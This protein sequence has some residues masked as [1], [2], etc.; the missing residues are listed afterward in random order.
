MESDLIEKSFSQKA[1]PSSVSPKTDF[2]HDP[3]Q[4]PSIWDPIEDY[5]DPPR[6]AFDTS[7]NAARNPNA[8]PFE[9]EA[10]DEPDFK[11]GR[12]QDRQ[13]KERE[14]WYD[15]LR[16][17]GGR[18]SNENTSSS[19][20]QSRQETKNMSLRVIPDYW[21]VRREYLKSKRIKNP[22][23]DYP[24]SALVK[25][26]VPYLNEW[27]WAPKKGRPRTF[28]RTYYARKRFGRFGAAYRRRYRGRG[29]YWAEMLTGAGAIG[30]DM[31]RKALCETGTFGGKQGLNRG[32]YFGSGAYVGPGGVGGLNN[33]S[34]VAP[35]SRLEQALPTFANDDDCVILSNEEY[36]GDVKSPTSV[37]DFQMQLSAG[38]NP[39]NNDLFPWLSRV[40]SMFQQYEFISLIFTYK[41]M[42]GALSTTQALGQVMMSTQYNVYEARPTTKQEMLNTVFA[43]SKVPSEDCMHAVECER[44][45]STAGGLLFIR[46]ESL[47][48]G[49]DARFYDLG[50]FNIATGGQSSAT[51]INLGQ[52]WVS[53]KVKLCKPQMYQLEVSPELSGSASYLAGSATAAAPLGASGS[54]S[55]NNIG[56]SIA[57]ISSVD[58]I[59]QFPTDI[60]SGVVQISIW[61]SADANTGGLVLPT[62]IPPAEW[63]LITPIG[64]ATPVVPFPSAGDTISTRLMTVRHYKLAPLSASTPSDSPNW[65]VQVNTD[66]VLPTTSCNVRFMLLIIPPKVVL[67][68]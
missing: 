27:V 15:V 31:A 8:E 20:R 1:R 7:N 65:L 35:N 62:I 46:G 50:N 25:R 16:R 51:P 26:Y 39:G 67:N 30:A 68:G 59:I 6:P 2:K 38:I 55:F 66:G 37:M 29:S 24:A 13:Q 5:D 33:S 10:P 52:L 22:R 32:L 12:S 17:K 44:A 56:A 48:A 4:D 53:Y 36:L 18:T 9:Y 14:S 54:F 47:P 3:Y 58:R 61:W 64:G 41:S 28:R 45:K 19:S 42:S 60:N 43:T 63:T 23:V 49:Q 40:A 34:A 11:S 57:Q 21:S